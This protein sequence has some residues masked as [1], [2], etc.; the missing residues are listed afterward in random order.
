MT[1]GG[2]V[3]GLAGAVALGRARQALLFEIDGHDPFVLTAAAVA[4]TTVAL[5]AGALPAIRASRVDPMRA[6]RR[7]VYVA[8][9][10]RRISTIRACPLLMA[11]ASGVAHASS[12]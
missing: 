7:C 5:T 9:E 3:L 12:S 1:A 11:H 10:T 8:P 6:L 2:G 4:L